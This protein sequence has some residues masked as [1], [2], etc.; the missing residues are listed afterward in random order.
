VTTRAA[1]LE[2]K[3]ALQEQPNNREARLLLGKAHLA[4]DAYADAEKELTRAKEQ[5][6]S[7]DE[8]LPALAKS[9]LLQNKSEKVLEMLP[10]SGLSPR[11][12]ASL[13][14]SRADRIHAR[15]AG[16]RRQSRLLQA[17]RL[18]DAQSPECA[19]F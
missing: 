11:S 9:L 5:G 19:P 2:L 14:V 12:M 6:A 13:Q 10:G 15:W 7:Y 18:A 17:A 8:V 4:S 16:V 1:I 3:S